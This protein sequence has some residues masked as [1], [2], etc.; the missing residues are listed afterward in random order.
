M[1][2]RFLRFTDKLIYCS[3]CQEYLPAST[4]SGHLRS[5]RHKSHFWVPLIQNVEVCRSAFRGRIVSYKAN[6]EQSH[7]SVFDFMDEVRA[8]VI[9]L[10]G[11]EVKKHGQVKVNFELF[12][13][14]FL[15]S[16]DLRDIKSFLTRNSVLYASTNL[17]DIYNS[18]TQNLDVKASNFLERDSGWIL[19]R[20]LHLEININKFNPLR[21]SSYI[22]LPVEVS[23]KQAVINIKNNDQFCFG[24][25]LMPAVCP[26]AINVNRVSSYPD[27]MTYFD[28]TGISFPTPLK[29]IKIFESQNDISL[30]VNGI[31][32]IYLAD[33]Q[34]YQVV[35]PLHYTERKRDRHIN[36]LLIDDSE[37]NTHYCYIKNLSRLVS[38]QFSKHNGAVNFCDIH[39][40]KHSEN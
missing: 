9:D 5:A 7:L 26:A 13:L 17:S 6:S 12:G 10:L 31:D 3:P 15:P 38:L 14:Y 37:G 23:K 39:F 27:F 33:K 18:F 22:P 11:N 20:F 28:F 29:E 34:K 25:S 40:C 4:Y 35:G 16:Q 24:W 21:A 36:L 30:N 1:L 19:E 32:K 2:I 8:S